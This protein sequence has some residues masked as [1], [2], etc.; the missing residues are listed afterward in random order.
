M[1]DSPPSGTRRVTLSQVAE[2]AGVSR[3]AV[4]FVMNGRTDQR[5]SADVFERVRRAAE[6]LGYRPNQTAKTLRTGRSGTIALVSDFVSST[7]YANAMVRG[8]MRALRERD[9]LLF[10]VDTEG[11]PQVEERLLHSLF[12]RDIDGV[13]Y[14]SMFT[15]IVDPPP[16]LASTRTVLLNC[17]ARGGDDVAVVPDEVEAGREAARLLVAAGHTDGIWFVGDLPPG[18]RGGLLWNEWGPLAL[19]ERLEGIERELAS[20]GL[21]LAGHAAVDDDWDAPN[22]QRA[23]ERLLQDGA[24]PSALICVNDAVAAGA[25][26]ALH[27]AEW[28]I[29]DDV[30]VIGFDGSPLAG[31]L[32]PSL[33]SIS[34]PHE[35]LGRRAATLLLS[36][37]ATPRVE[38]V[39]MAVH[40]GAS[41]GSPTR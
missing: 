19:P 28:R 14:T 1:T 17:R 23:V 2:R 35:D 10:T 9:I 32:E 13:I 31:M 15:R 30:S 38:R 41:V 34:L 24:R 40:L 4:S 33:T 18:R 36:D 25:Y 22:G 8:A 7:S 20:S 39:R 21:S 27:A 12:G 6:E 3:S 29:P 5:L 37:D 11:D 26:R 16:L